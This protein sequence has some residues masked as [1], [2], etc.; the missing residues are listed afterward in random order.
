MLHSF[1]FS[2]FCVFLPPSKGG[3]GNIFT[4]VCLS[5]GGALYDVTSC[6]VALSHVPGSMFLPEGLSP[7]GRSLFGGSLSKGPL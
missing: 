7:R 1:T 5:R 6:L 4:G 3:Q 2:V